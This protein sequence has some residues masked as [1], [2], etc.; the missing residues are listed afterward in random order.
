MGW[1]AGALPVAA[2]VRQAHAA[3]I[4]HLVAVPETLDALGAAILPTELGSAQISRVVAG[5]RRWIDGYREKAEVNHDYGGSRLRFTGPTPATRWTRQ[6]DELDATARAAHGAPFAAL[7]V[8]QRRDIV[9]PLLVGER[10]IPQNPDGATHVALA[11]LGFFYG[12]PLATDIC[13][14][15]A[16]GKNSCRPLSESPKHPAPRPKSSTG[17]VLTVR[18]DVEAGS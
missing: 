17:R 6:L 14:D 8:A 16:I 13:Y 15:A 5:F 4:A 18:A 9:R 7:T 10:G 11:L 3:S 12:S 2:I 1:L